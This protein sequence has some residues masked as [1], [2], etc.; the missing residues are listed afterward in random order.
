MSI[1]GSL[2]IPLRSLG[3]MTCTVAKLPYAAFFTKDYT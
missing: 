1:P 2:C 3:E